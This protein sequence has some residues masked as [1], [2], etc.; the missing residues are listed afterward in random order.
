M[1]GTIF[2]IQF[3][4]FVLM[5]LIKASYSSKR[6]N[7]NRFGAAKVLILISTSDFPF[8]FII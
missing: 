4:L 7:T 8:S 6:I 2:W 1:V 3:S 5:L